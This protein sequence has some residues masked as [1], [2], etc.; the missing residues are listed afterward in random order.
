MKKIYF[1]NLIPQKLN[2]FLKFKNFSFQSTQYPCIGFD[3]EFIFN[4]TL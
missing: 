4:N 2:I 3:R 1:N